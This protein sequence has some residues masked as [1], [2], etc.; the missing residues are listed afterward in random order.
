MQQTLKV[1][2]M[3][4]LMMFKAHMHG[5]LSVLKLS[6]VHR[7]CKIEAS[8]RSCSKSFNLSRILLVNWF[9]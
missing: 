6:Q 4:E 1:L 3:G 2:Q 7:L 8:G 5:D 9:L